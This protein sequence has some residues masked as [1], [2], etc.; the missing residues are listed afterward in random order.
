MK[1]AFIYLNFISQ[2]HAKNT[3]TDM[4]QSNGGGERKVGEILSLVT[5]A[6]PCG[7]LLNLTQGR[8]PPGGDLLNFTN[9]RA[10]PGGD[11]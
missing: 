3:V 4:I 10:P 7:D 6:P 5:R 9:G 8:A 11:L 1:Q 2:V